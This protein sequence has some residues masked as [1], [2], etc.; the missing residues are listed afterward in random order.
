VKAVWTRACWE[1]RSG[2]RVWVL[3][4]VLI[5]LA[6]GVAMAAAAGARRTETAYPRFVA[7]QRGYDVSIGGISGNVDPEQ[8][9][10]R[11]VRLPQV[12]EWSRLDLVAE[13]AELPSGRTVTAPELVALTDLQG[14]TGFTISR[15]KVLSGRVFD[16]QAPGEAVVEFS[17]A[18]RL[19]LHVGS[20][21]QLIFRNLTDQ[22][23]PNGSVI[24]LRSESVRVVGVVAGPGLF[25]AIGVTAPGL[26]FTSP[27][28]VRHFGVRLDPDA[29]LL[30]RLRGGHR[31][32]SGF[33]HD[34][35]DAGLGSVDIEIA[36]EKTVGVQRSIRYEVLALWAL[37]GLVAIAAFAALGQSLARQV[38]V[39]SADHPILRAIGMSH[40][41]LFALGMLR[42][43]VVATAGATLAVPV[44][45]LLSSWTPIGL[46]RIAEPTPGFAADPRVWVVGV[47]FTVVGFLSA[48]SVPA[49]RAAGV[50]HG[51]PSAMRVTSERPS[52]VASA[53]ARVLRS[54]AASVGVRMALQTGRGNAAVPV[55]SAA[56][57]SAVAVVA[58]VVS[59]VFGASLGRLLDTPRLSGFT[60]DVFV[61]GADE[62]AGQEARAAAALRRDPDVAIVGR[63]GW[64]NVEIA[65]RSPFVFFVEG[66]PSL[67]S[68]IVHGRAPVGDDELA[69]GSETM[70]L[71]HTRIG[72]TVDVALV[73]PGNVNRVAMRVVGEAV[74]PPAPFVASYR[75]G[76]GVTF[77]IGGYRR[78]V[79]G[80][81]RDLPFLV[82]F[83]PGA[84]RDA[85]IAGLLLQLPGAFVFPT[86]AT[87]QVV[88]LG[89]IASI[90]LVLSAL[91]AAL[92][93]GAL[94]H[95]LLTSIRRRR[96]DFAI[97]KT[98]G[99][100]RSQVAGV[101][102]WQATTLA[103]WAAL[104]GVPVGLAVGRWTWRSLA[105]QVGVDPSVAY[106]LI[107]AVIVP[108]AVVFANLLAL[109]PAR[110][111]AHTQ[112]A[113][114][115]RSE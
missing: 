69:L 111:A 72:G 114:V 49:W 31:D 22:N 64:D 62:S 102:A 53:L 67:R 95:T 70:R 58:L 110:L 106:P 19:R 40:R 2:S 8:A 48:G 76:E 43:A 104:V 42:V 51:G 85:A 63:G 32:V 93:A 59:V 98:L 5:A 105:S 65:G 1:F 82:R 109:V 30:L 83:K 29:G 74:I 100:V 35:A 15:F 37:A 14:R 60:W 91:L 101:V 20:V 21:I 57:G 68:P 80:P 26:V 44:S 107:I 45:W 71:A 92:A 16:P 66:D 10:A 13:R 25:P 77:T 94:S 3:L 11:I 12:V 47:L 6:A 84:D 97:L 81:V 89:G 112:V 61:A 23:L 55:R 24:P 17:T 7:A 113:Q 88:A 28:F 41:Q 18:A 86:R 90:P 56:L 9:R 103:A 38:F 50:A 27:A 46:A 78:V 73:R 87:S 115:L 108:A 34:L 79:A 54:A 75:P 36:R 39:D 52:A 33:L 4:A 96:R 99:F